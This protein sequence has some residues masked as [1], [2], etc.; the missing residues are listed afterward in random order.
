MD[1]HN[2][3]EK[4]LDYRAFLDRHGTSGHR[5]R[6]QSLYDRVG[7]TPEQRDLLAGFSRRMNVL[8]LAGTWCGDCVNQ[9]PILQRFA[10]ASD[11]IDLRFLD[12][13]AHAELQRELSLNGGN[14]VPVVVFL[15][16][17]FQEC[18]RYGDRTLSKYREMAGTLLG[19]AC[20][21]GLGR[22]DGALLEAVTSEWLNEFERAQ[23]MLRLSPR[24][25]AEHGD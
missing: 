15:S 9:C 14:R 19:A 8:C 24:L 11:R 2:A 17:D 20:P 5:D 4:A 10:E 6:W 23:L 22:Q 1:W 21:T 18:G 25:R 7:L 16:E 13:D 12:R 3:F